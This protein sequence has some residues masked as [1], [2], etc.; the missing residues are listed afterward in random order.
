MINHSLNKKINLVLIS[1]FNTD[2]LNNYL[3][4]FISNKNWL[5]SILLLPESSM[6]QIWLNP[7]NILLLEKNL[8]NNQYEYVKVNINSKISDVLFIS[9]FI[10]RL[11]NE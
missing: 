7:N 11:S 2:V 10:N 4:N 6:S 3:R 5:K 9:K 1:P 8:D